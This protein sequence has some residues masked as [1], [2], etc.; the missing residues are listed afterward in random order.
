MRVCD[1]KLKREIVCMRPKLI[2]GVNMLSF[3]PTIGFG[4]I[5]PRRDFRPIGNQSYK[6]SLYFSFANQYSLGGGF[7]FQ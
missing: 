2:W 4:C 7:C 1:N 3:S 5:C 6:L